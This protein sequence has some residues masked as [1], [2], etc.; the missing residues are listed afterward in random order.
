MFRRPSRRGMPLKSLAKAVAA[1]SVIFG[2]GNR[3]KAESCCV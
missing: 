2:P 1:D 3:S